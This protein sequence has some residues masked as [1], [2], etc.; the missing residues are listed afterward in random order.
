MRRLVRLG[1]HVV[2]LDHVV[3][4]STAY[5]EKGSSVEP[6]EVRVWLVG[7]PEPLVF[8][9]L[10]ARAAWGFFTIGI[11]DGHF[12]FA[13]IESADRPVTMPA[14]HLASIAAVVRFNAEYMSRS[15]GSSA[16]TGELEAMADELERL[17]GVRSN[18]F[19]KSR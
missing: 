4:V 5:G 18:L 17:A 8:D 2:N 3:H 6:T 13:G 14:S 19:P 15:G 7:R 9:D 16:P 1:E 10:L 11:T 12:C